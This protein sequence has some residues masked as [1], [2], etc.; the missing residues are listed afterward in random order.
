MSAL[1]WEMHF[2][3]SGTFVFGISV[4]FVSLIVLSTFLETCQNTGTQTICRNKKPEWDWVGLVGALVPLLWFKEQVYCK[5]VYFTEKLN[6]QRI[7]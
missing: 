2:R 6:I 7:E 3:N 5:N 1:L 4:G